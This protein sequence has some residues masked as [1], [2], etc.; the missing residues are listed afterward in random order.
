MLNTKFIPTCVCL[1]MES[2]FIRLCNVLIGLLENGTNPLIGQDIYNIRSAILRLGHMSSPQS[3][4]R[5]GL[6]HN[7][8]LAIEILR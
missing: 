1:P 6:D 5:P 2:S 3:K 7:L 4:F 8:V